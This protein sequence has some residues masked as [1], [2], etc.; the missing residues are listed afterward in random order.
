V[1]PDIAIDGAAGTVRVYDPRVF[2]AGRRLFCRRLLEEATRRPCVRQVEVD[3]ESASCRIEF[4]PGLVPAQDMANIVAA[5]VRDAAGRSPDAERIPMWRLPPDWCAL[6][7][8]T[9]SAAGEP[10]LWETLERRPGRI[11]IRNRGR[12]R[13]HG[14]LARLAENLAGRDGIAGC[15]LAHRSRVLTIDFR[16]DAPIAHRLLDEVERTLE[17]L[18]ASPLPHPNATS[19]ALGD[20][21]TGASTG[22][23]RLTYFA[24]ACGSFGLTLVGLVV[25]GI[26]TVPFLLATSYYLARSS[27]RLDEK[28]RQTAFFGPILAEWE[29]YGGL[30]WRSK[31]KLIGLA[32]FTLVVTLILSPLA[33]LTLVVVL[34]LWSLSIFWITRLPGLSQEQDARVRTGGAA[35][36]MHPVVP[37]A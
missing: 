32:G 27:P 9:P 35:S 10:S 21:A 16:P 26:P 34:V 6:T 24:L 37:V 2:R 20:A 33:P 36:L 17:E 19:W 23:H 22:L 7:A 25:P 29:Q 31:D 5:A 13:D 11:R 14:R 12:A 1:Q 30:S 18:R 8:Y 15:R 4:G 28:L 3:I